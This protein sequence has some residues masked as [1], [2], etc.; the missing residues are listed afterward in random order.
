MSLSLTKFKMTNITFNPADIKG[1]V[2]VMI[3]RRDT[4]KS[5]LVRDL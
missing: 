1:H 3:G 4:G 5:I 2:I